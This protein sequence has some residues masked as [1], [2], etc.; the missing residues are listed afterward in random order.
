LE[1]E[2]EVDLQGTY[3]KLTLSYG[4]ETWTGTKVDVSICMKAEIFKNTME[5]QKRVN[6]IKI[7]E[8]LKI[9]MFEDK[10]R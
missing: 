6:T 5:K 8:N 2:R 7:T 9:K 4:V 1:R 3:Y 10:L